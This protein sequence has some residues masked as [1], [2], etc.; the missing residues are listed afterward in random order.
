MTCSFYKGLTMK[1]WV[2]RPTADVPGIV[3]QV[4]AEVDAFVREAC[5][6]HVM[7]RARKPDLWD[8]F[9]AWKRQLDEQY[10][11][12]TKEEDRFFLRLKTSFVYHTGVAVKAD[13]EGAPGFYGLYLATA[14]K[15]CREV[16][17]NRSPNTHATVLK[18]DARG[19]VVAIIDSQDAF[20]HN[21]VKKSSHNVVKKSSQ[22]VCKEL[23]KCFKDG[24]RGLMPGDGYAYMRAKDH[25]AMLA[26]RTNAY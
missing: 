16:G 20:A 9:V 17:Y 11:P 7:G 12:P 23:S 22:H 1:P 26:A 4:D 15:E 21:V 19:N 2:P 10:V 24:M 18:L 5:E 3:A 25:A 14:S 13:G 8:A 6:V